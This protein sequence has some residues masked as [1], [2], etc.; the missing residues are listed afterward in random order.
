[1]LNGVRRRNRLM[2]LIF[3]SAA[4]AGTAPAI[5]EADYSAVSAEAALSSM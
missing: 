1:M 4:G 3:G 5:E 2:C